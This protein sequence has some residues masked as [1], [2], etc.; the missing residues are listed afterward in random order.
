MNRHNDAVGWV[1]SYP[2]EYASVEEITHFCERELGM[3][4]H[5][6][7]LKP[8]HS[9]NEFLFRAPA[10]PLACRCGFHEAQRGNIQ[11]TVGAG[12]Y[13]VNR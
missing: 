1:G 7:L 6:V 2:F 8:G 11:F 3:T 13:R 4:T 5:Q 9:C 10:E 12:F